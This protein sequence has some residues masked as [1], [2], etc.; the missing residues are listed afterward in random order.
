M[1]DV[2]EP[3]MPN[4]PEAVSAAATVTARAMTSAD[5]VDA[6]SFGVTQTST[7][8]PAAIDRG[9]SSLGSDRDR[10]RTSPIWSSPAADT[11]DVGLSSPW[12]MGRTATYP[13]PT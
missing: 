2:R 12:S 5:R 13:E 1:I 7:D 9:T 4:E 6:C 10:Y 8:E 11:A 3:S